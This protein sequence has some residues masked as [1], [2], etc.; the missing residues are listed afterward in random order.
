VLIEGDLSQMPK[1]SIDLQP[2]LKGGQGLDADNRTPTSTSAT[3]FAISAS[4]GSPNQT[5][6]L[7]HQ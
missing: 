4:D 3:H 7:F 6:S 2:I 1:R 5:S